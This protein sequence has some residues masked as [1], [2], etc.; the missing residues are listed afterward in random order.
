VIDE[1]RLKRAYSIANEGRDPSAA[2]AMNR[3]DF[4]GHGVLIV[5]KDTVSDP[6]P[7]CLAIGPSG[8]KVEL[9]PCFESWVPATL[10]PQWESGAVVLSETK[11]HTRW[12]VGPCT[13]D[14]SAQR[15]YVT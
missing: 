13:T 11:P 9:L 8:N 12:S 1:W 4:E 10:A 15:L 5:A 6:D 2:F 7:L 14:G 3:I